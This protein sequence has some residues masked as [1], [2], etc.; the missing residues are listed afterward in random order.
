MDKESQLI[1]EAYQPSNLMESIDNV[2]AALLKFIASG[3]GGY[4]SMNKGTANNKIIGSTHN[5]AKYLGR[6]L[7][8]LTIGQV[9]AL[10]QA[11]KLHAAGRYQIIPGTMK[12]I[13]NRT[14][15]S[16]DAMFDPST[17]DKLGLALIYNGQRP[18]LAGYLTG[19]HDD[20]HAAMLDM[21]R[22]WASMP[23][24]DTGKSYYGKG[25]KAHHS[26]EEV[27]A[28]LRAARVKASS[29]KSPLPV[30]RN[31]SNTGGNRKMAEL[32]HVVQPGDT[33]YRLHRKYRQSV[34]AIKAR[35][36]LTD[37]II[38]PGQKI[39]IPK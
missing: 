33:L 25:N 28:V 34:D 23:H 24:P 11:G 27:T 19:K 2:N 22:E 8:D 26:I 14:G 10:Q 12:L 9:M 18:A 15:I 17:Q 3:E 31:I 5:A 7:T 32:V 36:N 37:D 16:T 4:N 13:V 20:L 39:T 6:N 29:K 21:A 30:R 1:W 35:N 38:K